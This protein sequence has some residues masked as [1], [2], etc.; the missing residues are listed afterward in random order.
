MVYPKG[1]RYLSDLLWPVPNCCSLPD[2]LIH[3]TVHEKGIVFKE[4]RFEDT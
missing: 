1:T 2:S 3:D 4:T